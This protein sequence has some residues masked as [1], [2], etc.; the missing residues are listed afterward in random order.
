[1][2]PHSY[3]DEVGRSTKEFMLALKPFMVVGRRSQKS[4]L[5]PH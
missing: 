2:E 4:P 5:S 3:A 1:M